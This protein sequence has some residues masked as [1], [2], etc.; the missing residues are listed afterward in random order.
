MY[1]SNVM[2]Y[3]RE[4][5]RH[6][7]ALPPEI[8]MKQILLIAPRGRRMYPLNYTAVGGAG[9]A[10][11]VTFPKQVN[12]EPIL[13]PQDKE[14]KLEFPHPNIADQGEARVIITFDLRKMT[15]DGKVLY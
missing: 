6:W 14:L 1:S 11:Q 7:D 5:A 8:A 13:T 10:F 12:N 3:Y 15:V 9:G 2:T 4:F